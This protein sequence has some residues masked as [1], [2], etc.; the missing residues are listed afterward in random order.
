[1]HD[2]LREHTEFRFGHIPYAL[3]CEDGA[4]D[5]VAGIGVHGGFDD[6]DGAGWA[7][8]YF[9]LS[10][11]GGVYCVDGYRLWMTPATIEE[12]VT[13]RLDGE[14]DVFAGSPHTL[15]YKTWGLG[16]R[17]GPRPDAR[18]VLDL[19]ELPGALPADHTSTLLGFSCGPDESLD[20]IIEH[21]VRTDFGWRMYIN[22]PNRVFIGRDRPPERCGNGVLDPGEMC[23][24]SIPYE[25]ST[26]AMYCS[27]ECKPL[28]SVE[29]ETG[30]CGPRG[31]C[32]CRELEGL[33]NTTASTSRPTQGS[34]QGSTPA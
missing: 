4:W 23:D 30:G 27:R 31:L 21:I 9:G 14:R 3:P 7:I 1:M 13:V 19:G 6:R 17:F 33:E 12:T 29:C 10:S 28:G 2:W 25:Q 18:F 20:F 15:Y 22:W 24:H 8:K 11:S 5:P 34:T 26:G 32:Y 16:V